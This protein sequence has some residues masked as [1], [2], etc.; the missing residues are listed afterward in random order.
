MNLFFNVEKNI[1]KAALHE[2]GA[3]TVEVEDHY[4]AYNLSIDIEIFFPIRAKFDGVWTLDY[5]D[6]LIIGKIDYL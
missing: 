4:P 3:K 5:L 6:V 1:C 2:K